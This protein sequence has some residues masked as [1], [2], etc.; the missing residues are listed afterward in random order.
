M[1]ID[2]ARTF[3]YLRCRIVLADGGAAVRPTPTASET[4]AATERLTTLTATRTAAEG[5]QRTASDK[6][7]TARTALD[8]A[9]TTLNTEETLANRNTRTIAQETLTAAETVLATENEAVDRVKNTENNQKS[10]NDRAAAAKRDAEPNYRVVPVANFLHSL[11]ASVDVQ[12]NGRS[13]VSSSNNYAYKSYISTLL[14]ASRD[15]INSQYENALFYPDDEK[16][17]ETGD[18]MFQSNTGVKQRFRA[19]GG[20]QEF[21]LIDSLQIDLSNQEKLLI[22]GVNLTIALRK[23]DPKF[24]LMSYEDGIDFRVDI[25]EAVLYVRQVEVSPSFLIETERRL[26]TDSAKYYFQR[27]EVSVL[28]L[29]VNSTIINEANLSL[30]SPALSDRIVIGIVDTEA[31]LGSYRLNP[32]KF[33]LNDLQSINFVF[34]GQSMP[35]RM[36]PFQRD[37]TENISRWLMGYHSLFSQTGTMNHP[38]GS[39]WIS[40]EKWLHGYALLAFDFIPDGIVSDHLQISRG[41]V[42]NLEMRFNSPLTKVKSII[43]LSSYDSYLQITG[44]RSI[45]ANYTL[46]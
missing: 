11:F 20:S 27:V 29:A 46:G 28:P 17:F 31:Q 35:Y 9:I 16:E 37:K 42:L 4:Q 18:K 40:R 26:L 23:N 1:V 38:Q 22:P 8:T 2:L 5:R 14:S 19:T 32:F 41:G 34:N 10:L 30:A 7:T 15:A 39:S 21:E 25:T 36:V 24:C 3:L 44:D 33:E 6:V 13:V 43:M 45:L 12:L